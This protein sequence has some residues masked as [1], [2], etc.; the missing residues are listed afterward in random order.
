VDDL[1][2]RGVVDLESEGLVELLALCVG[3]AGQR[4]GEAPGVFGRGLELLGGQSFG[5]VIADAGKF[6][7]GGVAGDLVCSF[8]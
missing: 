5:W 8:R 1:L 4:S 7:F 3:G 6:C 2:A